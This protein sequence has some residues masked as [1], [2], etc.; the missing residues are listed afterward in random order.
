MQADTKK[1]IV[2]TLITMFA[3]SSFRENTVVKTIVG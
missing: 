1:L 3:I 2:I